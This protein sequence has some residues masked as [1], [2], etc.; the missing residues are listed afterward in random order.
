M[1]IDLEDYEGRAVRIEIYSML[2]Q[3]VRFM[4][5]D[6]VQAPVVQVDL[7]EYEAGAFLIRVSTEGAP[8]VTKWLDKK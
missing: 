1:N 6:E 2:G 4:E 7:S 5:I 8:S 3:M